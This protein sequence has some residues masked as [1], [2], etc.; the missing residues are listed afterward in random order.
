[1]KNELTLTQAARELGVNRQ[2]IFI[3]ISR[4]LLPAHKREVPPFGEVIYIAR[5]DFD[6]WAARS[7]NRRRAQQAFRRK[8]LSQF[9]AS[10]RRSKITRA[11]ATE[12]VAR[13]RNNADTEI[14]GA[15]D[16]VVL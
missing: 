15:Q 16:T 12:G 1:L 11:T 6:A 2:A 8:R 13:G 5:Q 4:G 9:Q 14:Y 3:A 7:A 10:S